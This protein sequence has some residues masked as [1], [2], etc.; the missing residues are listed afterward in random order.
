MGKQKT[1]ENLRVCIYRR[2]ATQ[3][4]DT[5]LWE[6]GSLYADFSD[7]TID[8]QG[9]ELQSHKEANKKQ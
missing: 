2:R 6:V 7:I 4:P 8:L 3:E 1:Q 9:Q 5:N